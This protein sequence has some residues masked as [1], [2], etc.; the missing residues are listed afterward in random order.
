[1]R[2]KV[3]PSLLTA[4]K[5]QSDFR[6]LLSQAESGNREAQYRLALLYEY[7]EAS[8]VPKNDAAA[9]EWMLRS[10]KQ[11]YA[12]AQ[13]MLGEMYLGAAGDRGKAERWLQRAAKQGNT[14]GH[15]VPPT[16]MASLEGQTI[17]RRLR[18]FAKPPYRETPT[19]RLVWGTCTKTESSFLRATC[20]LP[21]GIERRQNIPQTWAAQDKVAIN[22]DCCTWTV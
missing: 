13:A 6:T 12:P 20:W 11:E 1:M 5:A 10:P 17:S 2:N 15:L 8:S 16:R 9:R 7:P 18:G 22:W 4:D 21:S 14:E 3:P 19:P